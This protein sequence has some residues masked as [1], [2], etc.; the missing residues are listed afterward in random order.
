MVGLTVF[1][2]CL[3][4]LLC[5]IAG[6]IQGSAGIGFSMFVMSFA[7]MLMPYALAVNVNRFVGL[8]VAVVGL[9]QYRHGIRLHKML[10]PAL[11]GLVTSLIGIRVFQIADEALLKRALGVFLIA[12][13]VISLTLQRRKINLRANWVT[14]ALTGA[15]AGVASGLF[16]VLGPI[17]AVY[18][19]A[20]S[21]STEE[22][23]SSLNLTFVIQ[24]LWINLVYQT[25]TGYTG[26]EWVYGLIGTIA[27]AIGLLISACWVGKLNKEKVSWMMYGIILIMAVCML[28]T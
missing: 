9:W 18:Y 24:S 11:A 25:V 28:L 7:P 26:A 6:M 22:Y 17:L 12:M 8:T 2:G 20:V 1:E 13:V 15:L 19:M 21:E 3:V 4:F 27:S 5:G 16:N 14:G 23:R 10:P